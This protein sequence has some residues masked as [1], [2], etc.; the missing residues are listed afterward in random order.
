MEPRHRLPP[1]L[2]LLLRPRNRHQRP[3]RQRLPSRIHTPIPP[4]TTRRT[5]QHH[6]PRR[7]HRQAPTTAASSSAQWPTSTGAGCTR[8]LDRPSPRRHARSHHNG[9][10]SPSPNFPTATP[11]L[12]MSPDG[13]WVG[14]SV[15]EQKRVRIAERAFTQLQPGII[16]WLSLEPLREPLEFTDLSMFDWIVI[17]DPK[18]GNTAT[19]WCGCSPCIRPTARMGV[20]RIIA[21]AREA[22]CAIHRKPNPQWR[23]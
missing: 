9:N 8:R 11:A 13:A 18:T 16:K 20:S 21:Q 2:P 4:R 5:S 6:H 17:G 3:L 12:K 22:G 23:N 14:T 10:T 7:T 19:R 15:D 1:R